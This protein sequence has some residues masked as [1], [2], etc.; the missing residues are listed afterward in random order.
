[1][2]AHQCALSTSPRSTTRLIGYPSSR[3][4]HTAFL[5]LKARAAS[6]RFSFVRHECLGGAKLKAALSAEKPESDVL[7]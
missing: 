6:I 7:R 1:M 2:V 5:L 4:K 3:G